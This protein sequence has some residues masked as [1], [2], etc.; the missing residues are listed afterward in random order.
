MKPGV[1]RRTID[2]TLASGW[3]VL[4][5]VGVLAF[6]AELAF[7]LSSPAPT[8]LWE[9]GP[10]QVALNVAHGAPMYPDWVTGPV[11]LAIYGPL[12]HGMLA[13]IAAATGCGP[14]MLAGY[15]RLLGVVAAGVALVAA[16]RFVRASGAPLFASLLAASSVLLVTPTGL[17]FIASARPDAPAVAFSVVAL[18]CGLGKG[19][20]SA[21]LSGIFLTAAVETKMTSV[22]AA[23][24]IAA[25]LLVAR[26]YR[27]LAVVA[28]TAVV[29]N[30]ALVAG[31]ELAT[32]GWMGRH[33]MI[34]SAAPMRLHYLANMLS[35]RTGLAEAAALAIVPLVALVTAGRR[36]ALSPREIAGATYFLASALVALATATHQG[37]DQNYLIEPAIASGIVFGL[38]AARVG[39]VESLRRYV[40]TRTVAAVVLVGF[41]TFLLPGRAVRFGPA[42]RLARAAHNPYGKSSDAWIR[43]LPRPLL[44]LSPWLP[45]RAGVP[46]DL[47]DPIAYVC[48]LRNPSDDVVTRRVAAGAYKTIVVS[49]SAEDRGFV[50]DDIPRLWPALRQAIQTRYL[51]SERHDGWSAYVPR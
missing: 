39:R 43:S 23:I 2:A 50:Y 48:M 16:V 51:L 14:L 35:G 24:A 26:R 28:G 7:H 42:A 8:T 41:A 3:L 17:R 30:G 31:L 32:H 46:N 6:A 44:S 18:A 13:L 29:L 1:L 12:Y 49:L 5:A 38:W 40:V 19:R 9:N 11:Q 21:L 33:L 45:Y 15:A 36:P 37:S 25:A 22:A 20:A 34:P 27:R 4:T 10:L 47:N